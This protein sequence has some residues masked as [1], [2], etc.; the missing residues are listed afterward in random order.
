MTVEE[1][2]REYLRQYCLIEKDF[3]NTID[4]VSISQNNYSTFSPVYLKILLSIG[5]EIDVLKDFIC[6]SLNTDMKHL[7][8]LE[9]DFHLVEV[10]VLSESIVLMPWN[11]SDPFPTWWTVYNEVKHN[12][13]EKADR[14]DPSKKYYELANLEN[15]ISALAGLYSLELLAYKIV[16]DSTGEKVF[17][18]VIRSIFQV[19]NLYWT[20]ISNGSGYVFM[21]GC[22]YTDGISK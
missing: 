17:V 16:A 11:T 10:E 15:V 3:V 22:L 9:P 18:P 21:D 20:D 6:K 7:N 14:V 12:R 8:N 19:K 4:Y 13:N 2:K 1:F 5:S